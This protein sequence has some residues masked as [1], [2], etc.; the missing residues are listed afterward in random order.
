MRY[1]ASDRIRVKVF[2]R[3][4]MLD[5][6][7]RTSEGFTALTHVTARK[8]D[9]LRWTNEQILTMLVKRIFANDLI[10]EHLGINKE[11]INASASYRTECFYKV[12]PPTVYRGDNQSP[13]LR[14]IYNRYSDGRGVVTPRDVL[15]LVIAAKQRQQD[16]CADDL[17]GTSE[18][19]VG[20]TALQYGFQELSRRKRQTYLEAEFPHLWTSIE[21]L[22]DK[23]TEYDEPS[24]RALFGAKW[25]PIADDLVAIGVFSKSKRGG[26]EV[27]VIPFL[28]RHGLGLTRGKA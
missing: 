26:T 27:Y 21:K 8:T 13:T 19:I 23:K 14:W 3:D 25:K 12:F 22:V 18:W 16:L 2:L 24:L 28:Y 20:S 6:V 17:D 11:H 15:D 10:A 1:F 7:V 9:T 4:D 5:Q